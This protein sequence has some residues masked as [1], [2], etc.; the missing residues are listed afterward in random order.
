M[1]QTIHF[2]VEKLLELRN[3]KGG[4]QC[5]LFQVESDAIDIYL[6]FPIENGDYLL[7]F[8]TRVTANKNYQHTLVNNKCIMNICDLRLRFKFNLGYKW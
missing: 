2:N 1:D 5:T 4:S 7:M 3:S 8:K 6:L